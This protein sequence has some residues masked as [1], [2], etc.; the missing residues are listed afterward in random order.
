MTLAQNLSRRGTQKSLSVTEAKAK[1][2]ELIEQGYKVEE[3][4]A[5]VQ[6]SAETYRD[7]RKTDDKF[8]GAIDSIRAAKSDERNTGRPTV[9]DFPEFCADWLKQPLHDHQLKMWD[10]IEG[11]EPRDIHDAMGYD[12]GYANRILINVPPEHAKS[13]TFTV[14]Y[15]VWLI[16]KNPDIRV[17]IVSKGLK[18]AQD[19]LYE[20]KQKL[21][22]P[23]FREMHLRFAP[24]GGWQDPDGSWTGDRIYVRGK[25]ATDGV[26]KDPT[27]QAMGLKGTIYGRRADVVICDDIID[28]NN[29]REVETQLRTINR[30]ISS[31]LPSEEDIANGEACDDRFI[32][33]GTRVAPMDIYRVL[34]EIED[35]DQRRVWTYFRMPAVLDYGNGDS[36]TWVTLWP[37]KWPGPSLSRRRVDSGWNL[38][39]QQLDVDDDMTFKAEAVNASVNGLRFPG[40]MTPEGKGHRVGGMAGLY[41]AIGLDPAAS[42]NTAIIVAGL[43]PETGKRWVIDGWNKPNANATDI[44]EKFKELTDKY[45]PHEWVIE[46]NAFQRFLTQL[47][48]IVD[49]ARAR[50]VRITPHHTTANKFDEDWGVQTMG[51][52]FDSC[53]KWDEERKRWVSTGTGLI[54]LPSTR[55]NPWVN[56]LVQQLT[57]WQPQGMAQKQKTDL[58][59]AMW[60]TH[61]AFMAQLNRKT[62]RVT[63]FSSPFMS[64]GG[65]RR[66]TVVDLRALRAEKQ[67]VMLEGIA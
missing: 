49:Y 67:R 45:R 47:P 11:R 5:V 52:L 28:A 38:Y 25:N 46:K 53:V 10:V 26:Q 14:N 44:I 1:V 19:F 36:A 30:D 40:P 23:L 54:E 29:A 12:A 6:R 3:A 13:T 17:V 31:R 61:I 62:N 24:D 63:H 9:P 65:R 2:I 56:Q 42:G 43:D 7:W 60:F 20:I 22:S 64:P 50:G 58:V 59:M 32:I 57:I 39:Y 66:Q 48:D 4:C 34:G 15:V 21:T 35:G 51:P 33:L 27:V 8:K 18:L 16:H 41:V 37:K 55:Q